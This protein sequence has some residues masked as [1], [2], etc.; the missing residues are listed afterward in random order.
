MIDES[1]SDLLTAGI[2]PASDTCMT[3]AVTAPSVC[4]VTRRIV[5]NGICTECLNSTEGLL[6]PIRSGRTR[7]CSTSLTAWI[8]LMQHLLCVQAPQCLMLST[9]MGWSLLIALVLLVLEA[10]VISASWYVSSLRLFI[11]C[12]LISRPVRSEDGL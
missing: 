11:Y 1:G 7:S 5:M 8:R 6:Q 4:L 3:P 10:L 12:L 2:V 9:H